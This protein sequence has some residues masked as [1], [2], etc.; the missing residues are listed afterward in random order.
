MISESILIESSIS[1]NMHD[2][3]DNRDSNTFNKD[4]SIQDLLLN[5]LQSQ[6]K[7]ADLEGNPDDE[8]KMDKKNTTNSYKN[9]YPDVSRILGCINQVLK[10]T[11]YTPPNISPSG[12]TQICDTIAIIPAYN[13]ELTVGMVVMLSLQ[14]VGRVVVVDDGSIDR[15][16]EIAWLS[17]A[18]VV[19]VEPN[20]GKANAV[21]AGIARARE[22][23]CNA[24]VMLD[25]DGQHNPSEIP[26]LLDPI[27]SG[28]ADLVI[29]SRCL[30]GNSQEIPSYRRL[31]QITLDIAT[32]LECSYKCTDSQSGY[33]ALSKKAIERFDFPSDGYNLESDMIEHYSR[34]GLKITEVP[35]TVR[36][37]VPFKHKKNPLSHGADIITHI[38]GIIG[39]RR[40]LLS[41]GVSG[42]TCSLIGI[43]LGF[44]AFDQYYSTGKFVFIFT[45][46]SG[47]S[48][49]LG[50]LLITTGLILNSLVKIV[51]MGDFSNAHGS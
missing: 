32:N 43:I 14:H 39:Y 13:E 50:L 6:E 47:V 17:G 26:D 16:A 21:R 9:S 27:L 22:I 28:E 7:F 51:K 41:F 36:Y 18:D 10:L 38:I 23:G 37:E 44:F 30:N 20:K 31:G 15:T 24:M 34:I 45:M 42:F 49:V 11:R 1:K 2:F 35:I 40:P 46:F 19:R 8:I 48:M 29:G 5:P 4:S 3:H 12:K 33:R 25:A